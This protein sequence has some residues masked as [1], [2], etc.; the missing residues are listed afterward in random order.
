[1]A[2]RRVHE[3]ALVRVVDRVDAGGDLVG[4]DLDGEAVEELEH[5]VRRQVEAGVGAHGGAQ[6][7][8]DGGGAHPA[9][10]DVADDEGGAAS[11]EGDHVVPVAADRGLGAAGLVGGRDAQVVGLFQ[12]LGQEGALEGDGGLALAALAGAQ[13]LRGLGVVGDVRREDQHAGAARSFGRALRAVGRDRHGCAGECVGAAAGHLAGLDRAG[14]GAAQDLV[15]Q[16]QQAE[17]L[18]LGQRLA[19]GCAGGAV[20]EGRDVRVVHV[21]DAVV[22]AVDEGDEGGDPVED[23]A[24]GQFVDAGGG[25]VAVDSVFVA[26]GGHG[27]FPSLALGDAMVGPRC[28]AALRSG[29]PGAPAGEVHC[30]ESLVRSGEGSPCP[31][32][33]GSSGEGQRGGRSAHGLGPAGVMDQSD[34]PD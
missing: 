28:R 1:M 11:A 34:R 12:L 30:G 23:L 3:A 22:G 19:R 6:L 7:A 16:G 20:T 2:G 21:R 13:P 15:E 26:G 5:L 14:L 33:A 29:E 31:A 32:G 18:Q 9:A 27:A 4:V 8:H 10:H 24:C 17:F 25:R